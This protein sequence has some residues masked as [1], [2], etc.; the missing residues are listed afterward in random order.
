MVIKNVWKYTS[1]FLF[2]KGDIYILD[3]RF[4]NKADYAEADAACSAT[5]NGTVIDGEGLYAIPGLIDIHF[6]GCVT[7]DFCDGK[8][9]CLE[10]MAAYEGSVGVT[11]ICPASM[12]MSEED[13]TKAAKAAKEFVKI[14]SEYTKEDA[15]KYARL[16]GINMEGPFINESQKGAQAAEH[17]RKC[18]GAFFEGFNQASGNM[19]KLVDIAPEEEGAMEFIDAYHDKVRVSI[20][21]TTADY[22]TA[23]E[24]FAR[25]AKHVTHLY[26]AM[27]PFSH[28][29]PGVIGAACDSAETVEIICDGIHLHP[30][31]VRTSFQMFGAER[32]CL[33]SDSMR[34]TGMPDGN[35]SLGGQPVKKAGRRAVLEDGTIAGSATN[36]ADCMRTAV[37]EMDIPLE[38]AIRCAT[39][40][41]AKAMGVLDQYGTIE[42]GKIANLVLLNKELELEKVIING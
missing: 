37:L 39:Y 1:D 17:I 3:G 38:D 9:E 4:V 20:A 30:S 34:A 15:G 24:A 16:V 22:D 12:T 42:H 10:K 40:N 36:L 5:G 33:I 21:H 2:E 28:R 32:I 41:P 25:G 19:V 31:V 6:H 14:Q 8:V 35:Y 26:N 29:A 11:T 18:D 7:A 13:L 23:S 27:P